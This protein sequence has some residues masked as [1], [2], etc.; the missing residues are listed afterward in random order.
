MK[1]FA[2]SNGREVA[3]KHTTT[4]QVLLVFGRHEGRPLTAVPES[5]LRWMLSASGQRFL[6]ADLLD[7]I[8]EE[9]RSRQT[10]AE[11]PSA[12][13]WPDSRNTITLM[14]FCSQAPAADVSDFLRH[15]QNA[16][17]WTEDIL[18]TRARRTVSELVEEA[19][20]KPDPEEAER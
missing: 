15:L 13:T 5:Y 8:E 17:K 12:M 2:T 19:L 6:P 3:R 9:V 14:N 7:L 10:P 11:D 4:G 18:S 16:V 20:T 1:W